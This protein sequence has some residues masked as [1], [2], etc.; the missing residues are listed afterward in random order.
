[1]RVLY[2]LPAICLCGGVQHFLQV[3]RLLHRRGH[4]VEIWSPVVRDLEQLFPEGYE[5]PIHCHQ[6]VREN[7][8]TLPS[9][10]T[11]WAFLKRFH[12]LT[13]GLNALA[14]EFPVGFDVIHAGFFPNVFAA[15]RSRGRQSRPVIVQALHHPPREILQSAFRRY[16]W[17]WRK[18]P[19]LA[20]GILTVSE[21][22][23]RQIRSEYGKDAFI[24][25]NGLEP[26]FFEASGKATPVNV[27]DKGDQKVL[28]YVGSLTGRKGLE[29]LFE[30][31]SRLRI[32]YSNLLLVLVGGGYLPYFHALADRYG[33]REHIH[34]AGQLTRDELIACYDLADV[35]CF[36]SRSEGF[37]IPPL[38]AMA[39]GVPVV[40][41]DSGGIRE[42]A[43]QEENCLLTPVNDP[44]SFEKAIDRLF[45]T[46]ELV[47]KLKLGGRNTASRFTWE[48]V[49]DRTE[50]AF[51]RLLDQH[52]T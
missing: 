24:V 28:L 48:Q 3:A 32:R 43:R 36:P 30:A 1:M 18:A 9:E 22:T 49:T 17:I 11:P 31:F 15:A 6:R 39:R 23:C 47:E 14:K 51:E 12:A 10:K 7:L 16:W 34:W 20:D 13:V 46:P 45:Q 35:F 44:L 5:V 40:M 50:K 19:H 37:G 27:F 4:Q 33:V 42:Y 52:G 29:I 38:E 41:T 25:G 26:A 21:H 2:S 8:Y